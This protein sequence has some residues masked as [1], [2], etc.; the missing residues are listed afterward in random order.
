ME[1]GKSQGE[2]TPKG[3]FH[4]LNEKCDNIA[5]QENLLS[6]H[7]DLEKKSDEFAALLDET[8]IEPDKVLA[9][10]NEFHKLNEDHLKHEEDIMMPKV[11]EMMKKGE[12]LKKM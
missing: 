1:D 11:M 3:F 4:I 8:E 6:A 5:T 2:S 7:D 9:V 10:Y 12:P